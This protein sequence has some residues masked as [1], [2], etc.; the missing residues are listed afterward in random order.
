MITRQAEIGDT[1]GY[2]PTVDEE[3]TRPLQPLLFKS[4]IMQPVPELRIRDR[5]DVIREP[6]AVEAAQVITSSD[7]FGPATTPD[8]AEGVQRD[9]SL[10]RLEDD[11]I[12][13]IE[14][15]RDGVIALVGQGVAVKVDFLEKQPDK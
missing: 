12:G 8:L 4:L 13:Q 5:P 3:H 9:R 15:L 2:L 7:T 10:E 1:G 6:L 11:A 14:S